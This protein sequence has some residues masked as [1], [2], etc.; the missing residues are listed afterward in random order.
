MVEIEKRGGYS[1]SNP[2]ILPKPTSKGASTNAQS[3]SS[4]ANSNNSSGG[5][6]QV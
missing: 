4:S 3:D 6:S 1:G 2:K 5:N